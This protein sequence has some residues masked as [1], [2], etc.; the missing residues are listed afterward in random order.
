MD[1]I[2]RLGLARSCAPR[3]QVRSPPSPS[4]AP[5]TTKLLHQLQNMVKYPNAEEQQNPRGRQLGQVAS[6]SV[7]PVN[8]RET[9][10]NEG[11]KEEASL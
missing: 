7:C 1:Q 5:S 10:G 9:E 6:S 4:P 3:Q 8:R 11:E 2:L